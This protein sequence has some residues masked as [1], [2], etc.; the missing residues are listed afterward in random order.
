[1]IN[2]YVNQ[3]INNNLLLSG[4]VGLICSVLYYLENK[5]NKT[6]V[7]YLSYFKLVILVSLSVYGVLYIKNYRNL[8]IGINND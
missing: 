5:R 3:V 2:Q 6:I 1:M 7:P 4:V 8:N